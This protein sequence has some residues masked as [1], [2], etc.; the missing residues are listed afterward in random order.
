ME[1]ERCSECGRELDG[2]YDNGVTCNQCLNA[3]ECGCEPCE[4]EGD[5]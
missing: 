1:N 5:Y 2:E 3:L 4:W